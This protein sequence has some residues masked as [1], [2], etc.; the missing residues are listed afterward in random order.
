LREFIQKEYAAFPPVTLASIGWK[1]GVSRDYFLY[2]PEVEEACKNF[3]PSPQS[4]PAFGWRGALPPFNLYVLAK[5]AREFGG[6]PAVYNAVKSKLA[7]LPPES[8][9]P[10]YPYE[11]NAYIA[12]HFGYLEL[13]KLAGQPESA[14]VRQAL[15][16]LLAWRAANFTKDT[17]FPSKGP[18]NKAQPNSH[19]NRLNLSRN[20]IH[21]TPELAQ[22]LHAQALPKVQEAL[23]EYNRVGP[24]WFVSRY[25]GC[26]QEATI[27]NLY[28]YFALFQAKAWILKQPRQEL[29]KYLDV[30]GFQ[31]G[32]CFYIHNLISA[33]QAPE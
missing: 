2:P 3:P 33:L 11:I 28:D 14:A 13:E 31:R 19:A 6:A 16:K 32:D 1:D 30:P 8:D 29:V 23:E 10:L 22:H 12:G 5:Y 25:E 21:L 4:S 27:Q 7:P 26:L 20:F 17:P 9:W 24:Y 18:Y 15:D